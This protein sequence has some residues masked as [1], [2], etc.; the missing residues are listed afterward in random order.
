VEKFARP[1]SLTQMRTIPLLSDMRLLAKGNRLSVFPITEK[2]FEIITTLA[3]TPRKI[4]V[5]RNLK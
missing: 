5:S 2:H 3:D 4:M 1:I